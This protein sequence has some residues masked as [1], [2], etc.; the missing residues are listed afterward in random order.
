M[1]LYVGAIYYPPSSPYQN[2][3]IEL[4]CHTVDDIRASDISAIIMIMGDFNNLNCTP[5]IDDLGMTQ[6]ISFPTRGAST[7]DKTFTNF[8]GL[9]KEPQRSSPLG[10][11]DHC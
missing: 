11:S 8:P 4:V 7:L 5:L 3:I 1:N 6:L 2:E 10:N 9:F